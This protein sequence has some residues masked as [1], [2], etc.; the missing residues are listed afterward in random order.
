MKLYVGVP[1]YNKTMSTEVAEDIFQLLLEIRDKGDQVSVNMPSSPFISLNRNIIMQKG[2]DSDYILQW[3]S[4]IQV[5]TPKFLYK[6]IETAYKYDAAVVGLLCRIKLDEIEYACGNMAKDKS[7]YVRLTKAPTRP[8][9]V[10]VIG[11]GVT[12]IKSDWVRNNLE[13]PYYEFVDKKNEDGTPGI[14]P[15][16]WNFCR[17]VKDAGGKVVV[18]PN[19]ST[20]HWGIKGFLYEAGK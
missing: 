11:A 16:D 5:P 6:M 9:E 12:L 20:V 17:K 3:D 13:Q 2:L 8:K 18:E 1:N 15:E 14:L 7:G 10:D 19:I 4:D